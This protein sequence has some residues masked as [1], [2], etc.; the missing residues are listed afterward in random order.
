MHTN[1]TSLRKPMGVRKVNV[2]MGKANNRIIVAEGVPVDLL[3]NFSGLAKNQLQNT[4]NSLSIKDSNKSIVKWTLKY[5]MS[6]ELE[7]EFAQIWAMKTSDVCMLHDFAKY[8]QCPRL[9]HRVEPVIRSRISDMVILILQPNLENH[10]PTMKLAK[11]SKFVA[12]LLDY[13]VQ[14][15]LAARIARGKAYYAR[16]EQAKKNRAA[17]RN[18]HNKSQVVCY[19][20]GKKGHISRYC[21]YVKTVE[22][23]NGGVRTCTRQVRPGEVTRTGLI[24]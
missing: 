8:F 13:A 19:T 7:S 21:N 11:D 3:V 16:I 4:N 18:K 10:E 12:K 15:A 23:D 5:M 14:R 17:E 20:R 9:V 1:T 24:I 6:G 2:Y 22:V